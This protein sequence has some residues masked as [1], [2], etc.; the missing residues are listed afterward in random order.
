[1]RY[2]NNNS[3]PGY[4]GLKAI[5]LKHN[6]LYM[7][8]LMAILYNT[9]NISYVIPYYIRLGSGVFRSATIDPSLI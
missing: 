8:K 1:M 7:N 6:A 4:D 5:H 3:A 2:A 9:W